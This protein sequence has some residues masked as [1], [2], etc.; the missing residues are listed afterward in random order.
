MPSDT[1]EKKKP[2]K[3]A[4]SKLSRAV[5]IGLVL[6][7][8][9]GIVFGEYCAPLKLVGDVFLGRSERVTKLQFEKKLLA[10]DPGSATV[11]RDVS[12]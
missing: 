5:L 12:L 11:K 6:G 9:A 10:P 2:K 4:S 7:V 1:Q 8:I 3:D